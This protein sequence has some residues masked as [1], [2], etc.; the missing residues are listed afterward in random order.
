MARGQK[1]LATS[2]KKAARVQSK[3]MIFHGTILFA[4]L[5]LHIAQF[6]LG[7]AETEG[8]VAIVN[9]VPMRDLYRLVV[10]TFQVPMYLVIYLFCMVIVGLH[11]CHGF[12]SSFASLGIYHPKL[13]PL[14]NKAGYLYAAVVALGF[15][16]P[17]VYLFF[18]LK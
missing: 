12:Y 8:Y 4:F 10:E 3:W 14:L 18:F 13:S 16:V 9:G 1:T 17:P 15:I 5:I 11:L 7:P 2:G 6:K